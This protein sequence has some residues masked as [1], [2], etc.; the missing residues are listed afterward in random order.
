MGFLG[1]VA[2]VP[3]LVRDQGARQVLQAGAER[4]PFTFRLRDRFIWLQVAPADISPRRPLPE[5]MEL[6]RGR[7]EDLPL[8]DE[9]G[10]RFDRAAEFLA[11]GHDWWLLREAGRLVY[12]AWIFHGIAPFDAAPHGWIP[13]PPRTVNLED[14]I[15]A[16]EYRGRGILAAA[17]T[18]IFD[19]LAR[20]GVERMVT[21]VQEANTASLRGLAKS[22]WRTFAVVDVLRYGLLRRGRNWRDRIDPWTP[23]ARGRVVVR[24]ADT[25]SDPVADRLRA[26]LTDAVR[27]DTRGPRPVPPA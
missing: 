17:S 1:E 11:A 26:W 25:A 27:A 13:L 3:R 7:V 2:R 21:V 20:A 8:L 18:A 10:A 12:S 19:E 23:L 22:S 4:L 5:G 6:T 15:T 14:S 16:T 9:V 24:P